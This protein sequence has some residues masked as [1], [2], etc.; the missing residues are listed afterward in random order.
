MLMYLF[1]VVAILCITLLLSILSFLWWSDYINRKGKDNP[2]R[3]IYNDKHPGATLWRNTHPQF[4]RYVK[5]KRGSVIVMPSNV[6]IEVN[7]DSAD[8]ETF[9]HELGHL[10]VDIAWLTLEGTAYCGMVKASQKDYF[11]ETTLEIMAWGAAAQLGAIDKEWLMHL[12]CCLYKRLYG[13]TKIRTAV[14]IAVTT[15]LIKKDI[16]H[17]TRRVLKVL[18]M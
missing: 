13:E 18:Y 8:T 3:I 7:P 14:M 10:M 9:L 5:M 6:Y 4:W 17:S 12:L 1:Y 16:V 2:F 11:M 15:P